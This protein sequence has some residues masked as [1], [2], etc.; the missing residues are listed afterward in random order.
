MA[1]VDIALCNVVMCNVLMFVATTGVLGH[2]V[3]ATFLTLTDL[4]GPCVLLLGGGNDK[5]GRRD[6]VF[7]GPREL[8]L[9]VHATTVVPALVSRGA[10]A[11]SILARIGARAIF[12]RDADDR[13]PRDLDEDAEQEK[14]GNRLFQQIACSREPNA[15][16]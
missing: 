12:F 11:R 6:V 3:L 10:S 8:F 2:C 15:A 14:K 7:A 16:C 13:N 4:R 9:V 5:I 1:V